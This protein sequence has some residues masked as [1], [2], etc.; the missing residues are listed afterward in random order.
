MESRIS[1]ARSKE[2]VSGFAQ[3]SLLV[4]GD[5]MIDEYLRGHARRISQESPV[6]VVEVEADDF[7]PGGA[8]NVGNNLRALGAGV[9]MAGVVGDDE[10]GRLLCSELA[11]QEIDTSGIL[12]DASRPTTRKTR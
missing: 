6:M 10:I 7:K 5:L 3:R 9:Y 11:E 8:A 2:I 1:R 4:I 12:T